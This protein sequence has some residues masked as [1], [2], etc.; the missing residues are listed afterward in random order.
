MDGRRNNKGTKGNKGGNPGHGY[1][2]FIKENVEKYGEDWWSIWLIMLKGDD[3]KD[4]Q[5]AMTEFNKLQAK[6][7]P[8]DIT[9]NNEPLIFNIQRYGED[10]K[11]T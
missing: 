11:A 9:S 5:I 4:R 2:S 7:I 6:M 3:K 8:Q 1:L 10:I